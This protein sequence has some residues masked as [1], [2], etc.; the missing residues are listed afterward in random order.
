MPMHSQARS[1]PGGAG[2]AS[3]S[4]TDWAALEQ[5]LTRTKTILQEILEHLQGVLR[6]LRA[7]RAGQK[8]WARGATRA[9]KP[10]FRPGRPGTAGFGHRAQ[11][12]KGTRQRPGYARFERTASGT[13]NGTGGASASD[14]LS[15]FVGSKHRVGDNPGRP[16]IGAVRPEAA[17]HGFWPDAGRRRP[18][19]RHRLPY[20]ANFGSRAAGGSKHRLREGRPPI[21]DPSRPRAGLRPGH[22]RKTPDRASRGPGTPSFGQASR[23]GQT[24]AFQG[25][26]AYDTRRETVR[27]DAGRHRTATSARNAADR[28]RAPRA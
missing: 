24:R 8:S 17:L 25:S 9:E 20:R 16:S 7:A 3:S 28:T 1:D 10:G 6:N 15:S 2:F 22:P 27:P 13:A 23:P 5:Q 11:E 19:D 14:V 21:L 26:N 12:A 18:E 4:T